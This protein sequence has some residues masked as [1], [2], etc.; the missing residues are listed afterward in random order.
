MS[1]KELER[2]IDIKTKVIELLHKEIAM[3]KAAAKVQKIISFTA[4]KIKD[5]ELVIKLA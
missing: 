4:V 1:K 5:N 3:L 2:E